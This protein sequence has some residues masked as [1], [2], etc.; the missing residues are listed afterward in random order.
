MRPHEPVVWFPAVRTGTGTDVFV[1]ELAAELQKRGLCA[2][3]TWLPLRAEY[4]PW[5]VAVPDPPARAHMVHVNTWL[6]PRFI[7][8]GLPVVATLHHAI[9]H[10]DLD[11]YK[12]WLRWAYHRYWIRRVEC[13][14][15][16]RADQV[17]AVSRFAAATAHATLLDRAI[18]VIPNGIDIERFR[19]PV[20]R[21]LHHPFRLLYVGS[22]M[23]R[24]GVDLLAPIMR[25]LGDDFVLRYTG[26][27]AADRHRA[28]MPPNMCDIGRLMGPDAVVAAMQ[29]ADAL[30]F[31]SRSE[32]FGLVAAEAM[33]CGL[34]VI[35]TCGSSLVEVVDDGVT[36]ILCPRDDI[37]AFAG[38]A[39]ELA[40]KAT[41][42]DMLSRA[43][44]ATAAGYFSIAS[45]ADAYLAVYGKSLADAA[46][47]GQF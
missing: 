5:T 45:M 16:R 35:A 36:G 30:L 19:P 44:R 31:P 4:A 40:A 27:P 26:G 29:D 14:T 6:H 46:R 11:P 43:A 32:G 3:I 24:K 33:A 18:K 1:Q 39:R 42:T 10:P 2:E 34:P 12:G 38:A 47:S 8:D 20:Q 41:A 22:W 9:H 15:M 17:V 28:A 21:R 25:R 13:A 37:D 23:V 7:P